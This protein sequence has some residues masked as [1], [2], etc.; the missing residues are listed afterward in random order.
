MKVTLEWCNEDGEKVSE[1]FP[2]KNAV[3]PRCEGNGTHLHNAIAEHAYSLEE[4]REAFDE[5]EAAEYFRRGG[6]YDVQCEDCD[7]L[8]VIPAVD[9]DSLTSEQR[10]SLEAFIAYREEAERDAY[11]ERRMYEAE[12]GYFY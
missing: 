1:E 11:T 8:Q 12:C 3:C 4:F 6:R 2:A 9:E 7:G 10:V 5:E